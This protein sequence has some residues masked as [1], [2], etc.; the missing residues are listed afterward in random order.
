MRQMVLTAAAVTMGATALAPA[1]PVPY[2][3]F[4][5]HTNGPF[6]ARDLPA[7]GA[8][9]ITGVAEGDVV[10]FNTTAVEPGGT[11][12]NYTTPFP[13]PPQPA[14]PP[15]FFDGSLVAPTVTAADG[16]DAVHVVT[17]NFT[18]AGFNFLPGDMIL[19]W[20]AGVTVPAPV[21]GIGSSDLVLFRPDTFGDY[22]SG[23]FD[24]LF[25]ASDVAFGGNI[26]GVA[27]V[28][29][30][31]SA[32]GIT[33]SPGE[34]LIS[35]GGTS[36]V[37]TDEDI[38]RFTPTVLGGGAT[39]GAF[40]EIVDGPDIVTG[41][42]DPDIIDFEIIQEN[43]LFGD[44]AL[45]A[46]SI[47][48]TTLNNG[49]TLNSTP[50][51]DLTSDNDDLYVLVPT[52]YGAATAGAITL[53]FNGDD[54]DVGIGSQFLQETQFD[55]VAF[56]TFPTFSFTEFTSTDVN[57][58]PLLNTE[59]IDHRLVL[60][61]T[62]TVDAIDA[63][64]EIPIDADSNNLRNILASIGTDNSTGATVRIDGITL[65]AGATMEIMFTV[66]AFGVPGAVVQ[67][68]ATSANLGGGAATRSSDPL[69]IAAGPDLS[70]S[71]KVSNPAAPSIVTRGQV[72]TYTV[73]INN[74]GGAPAIVDLTDTLPVPLTGL[75]VLST[76]GGTDASVGTVV[77]IQD[78]PVAAGG[79]ASVQFQATVSASALN[80]DSITNQ[81]TLTPD[82]GIGASPSSGTLT[83]SAEDLSTSTKVSNPPAGSLVTRGQ[84]V[85][86]TITINNTG[87]VGTTVDLT[88]SVNGRLTNVTVTNTGG[89][90]DATVGNALAVDDIPLPGGSSATVEFTGQVTAT[91]IDGGAIPNTATL[92]PASGP[93][94]NVV[95]GSLFVT[96]PVLT[97][98]TKVSSPASGSVVERGD[99]V[100]YTVSINNTGSANALVDLTDTVSALLE[101]VT[102]TNTGGGTDASVGNSVSVTAIPVSAGGTATVEITGTVVA[103]AANGQTFGN[104]ATLTPNL[105]GSVVNAS[106][107]TLTVGVPVLATSTKVS[108]PPGGSLV[109]R[110]DTVTYT[111]TINNTGLADAT[112]DLTDAVSA[113]LENVTVTSTGGGTDASAGNS[114]SVTGIPVSAGGSATVEITGDVVATANDGDTIANTATLTPGTGAVANP[115]AGT[116]TVAVPVL[117]ASTKTS[118]PPA[119]SNLATGSPI[120]YT[121]TITNSGQADA[122][123]DLLDNVDPLLVNVAVTNAGGGVD[124]SA[125]N[126]VDITGIPVT[127][128]SSVSVEITAEVS[129]SAPG[130]A[131]IAN[132]ATLTPDAGSAETVS[133]GAITVGVPDLSTST[134]TSV[135]PAGSTVL[136]GQTV[137]YTVTISNTGAGDAVVDLVDVIPVEL[138][139]LS[140][141]STGGGIDS[142]SGNTIQV[143]DILVVGGGSVS[144]EFTGQVSASAANG[145]TISHTANLTPDVGSP[146]NLPS[147]AL[148][149]GV[150]DLSTS[151][152]VSSPAGGSNVTRGDVVTYTITI[153][154]TGG[155]DALVDVLDNVDADLTGV[156]VTNAGGGVDGSAGNTVSIA[157]VPVPAG[158]SATVI[159][160]A[161]VSAT[162]ANG[163]TIANAA[164]LT[165]DTGAAQPVSS[166]ALT[167]Q[168]GVFS[169][170]TKTSVPVPGSQVQRGAVVTYTVTINN[171][172]SAATL[173]DLTDSV[174]SDLTNVVVT[175]TGGGTNASSGNAV[176]VNNIPVPAG[177]S[178][179]VVIAGQVRATA[180]NGASI[181]NTATV[182]PDSGDAASPSSGALTVFVGSTTPVQ[183]YESYR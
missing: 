41:G 99:T 19:S 85:T 183:A 4:F 106:A 142:S 25:D 13:A 157:D 128:G 149:A 165:P 137:T 48:F 35:I 105:G 80:G 153:N 73:T 33:F 95:S 49:N 131:T 166:A 119:G 154:N 51:P 176:A 115:G 40:D 7:F 91:A 170:S 77:D 3:L 2:H 84:L 145:A 18:A 76:G 30:S 65:A 12:G 133:A 150:P 120:T 43:T 37:F 47:V 159:F 124:N 171:T 23:T 28:E 86:Y 118:N 10:F 147:G 88:D 155:G 126:T 123:V 5:S 143:D 112:V 79:S 54:A 50:N 22:T 117:T 181:T 24:L 20:Q 26:D 127:A 104:T 53:L 89:G 152:K 102:V 100:I 69:T 64:V 162:A 169:A 36:G 61:N 71:T 32:G 83:V 116:L 27:L 135:P 125:G 172:G 175:S 109:E 107:G 60:Q 114:V 129:G 68:T 63:S 87:A 138:V 78:I 134:F 103:T 180:P 38:I 16:V 11:D 29:E 96:V 122:L 57:G 111:V 94:V 132:S 174:D 168:I 31:F 182:T 97:T 160:T 66:D 34:L 81:C 52:T 14:I 55:G 161:T 59:R 148:T 163:A 113:L 101:N 70:T 8:A 44:A 62:S 136:R 9:Q 75:V 6:G 56:V 82:S 21:G 39:A 58:A 146:A 17:R 178:A 173:V 110:G 167:V 130:G 46:G 140:V 45:T 164:T 1:A 144:V 67:H 121:V 42:T 179:T 90:T 141:T 15:Y 93:P 98:S 177:G 156:T 139:S 151:T 74:T 72:I 108:N 158:G 92:T